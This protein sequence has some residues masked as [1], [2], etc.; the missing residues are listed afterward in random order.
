MQLQTVPRNALLHSELLEFG[1]QGN[2][3]APHCSW[4]H[5]W[6]AWSPPTDSLASGIWWLGELTL[7]VN[8]LDWA[9]LRDT[10]LDRAV[11]YFLGRL[12]D[13]EAL[14]QSGWNL[15]SVTQTKERGPWEKRGCSS[16]S[17]LPSPSA[18]SEPSFFGLPMWIT[19]F[20][21]PPR[22]HHSLFSIA[23]TQWPVS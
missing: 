12:I 13:R 20:Q 3:S 22:S 19:A 18:M 1:G 4:G 17:P 23:G 14:P 10:T 16:F 21:N 8:L 2:S 5:N 15:L 7:I 6:L 9:Q 11:G